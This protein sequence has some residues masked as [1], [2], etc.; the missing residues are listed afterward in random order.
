MIAKKGWFVRRKY[1][2]WG[3]TPKSWQ[4][5]TYIAVLIAPMISISAFNITPETKFIVSCVWGGIMLFAFIDIMMSVKKDERETLHE[6]LAERNALWAILTV[7]VGGILYDVAKGIA[8]NTVVINPVILI[9][10]G[11]G[12]LVKAVSN[13]YL[14]RKN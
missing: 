9:A 10:L 4:G 8:N 1:S 3:F 7:L 11:A 6:A 14:D 2:G 5:W 13:F 12:L